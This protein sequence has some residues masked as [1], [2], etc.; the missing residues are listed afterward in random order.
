MF[1]I[2]EILD[3]LPH[4]YPLLLVDRILEYEESK[5]IVALKNVTINEPFF[6][7]HFPGT[8]IMPGVLIIESMAQVGGFLVFKSLTEREKKLVF[9]AGIEK[10]RFRK[11]VQPGDQLTVE[12][13]VSRIRGRVGKLEGKASVDGTLVAEAQI[14]FSLVDRSSLASPK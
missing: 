5:R 4:R 11:P 1:D 7:G 8:P 14:M 2:Q 6:Q 3:Y 10:A 9:F 13:L 12:M